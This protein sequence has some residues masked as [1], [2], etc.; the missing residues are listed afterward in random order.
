MSI[1]SKHP[2]Y[3]EYSDDWVKCRDAYKGQ[4]A[5]KRG[6][7][8]YLPPTEG[9][10]ADGMG[11]VAGRENLGL[12]RYE[13]Y[14]LRATYYEFV[15][16]A[17]EYFIGLLHQKPANIELPDGMSSMLE[18]ATENG[19][20][21]QHL[22]RRINEQQLVT[23]RLGLLLDMPATP[24][25]ANPM[26][27]IALYNAEAIINWDDG[28]E[29]QTQLTSLNLVVLDESG[30]VR[31][32][33]D[34]NWQQG[35][36][37]RV[38]V[39]GNPSANEPAGSAVTYRVAVKAVLPGDGKQTSTDLSVPK[40]S[41]Y[42]EPTI[43]GKTLNR[44]PFVFI[45]SKDIVARPDDPPLLGLVNLALAIYRGD[46]DY[47]Q[48]LHYQGQ[49]TLVITG[50]NSG[51]GN[52]EWRTGAGVTIELD[53]NGDAKYIGPSASGLPEQRQA[54][55]N[56]KLQAANM[57]G[58]L[59]DTRSGQKE[60]GEALK[61][62]VTSQTAT[63][64]QLALAGALGLQQLLRTAA[65][66]MGYDPEAVRVTPNLEF[67]EFALSGEDLVKFMTA[68]AMGAPISLES[69]HS[70]MVDRGLTKL[71]YEE[72]LDKTAEEAASDLGVPAGTGVDD[73]EDGDNE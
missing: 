8:A 11:G 63:L 46:A 61:M 41:D 29:D 38:L 35:E 31:V 27:Y 48:N 42:I 51:D 3:S 32:P 69:I 64:N 54:L 37:Y 15:S 58:Q 20:S 5:V 18:R 56:D 13:D 43:R 26:P 49:D 44:I 33:G 2:F 66:W 59:I 62:R 22:L 73:N 28:T 55:E 67:G 50:G 71:T 6:R 65:E 39:L 68:R 7:T 12:I 57:A 34:F 1:N 70:L 30:P 72:E 60:S 24:D 19:E 14:L 36:Q 9:M 53:V 52:S 40:D 25:P 23:G 45:N 47:R 17:V 21:L 10:R 4:T 16:G